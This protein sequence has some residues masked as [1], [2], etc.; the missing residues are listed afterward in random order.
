MKRTTAVFL[1][2]VLLLGA[3][4]ARAG[5]P[6]LPAQI[7]GSVEGDVYRNPYLG[8]GFRAEGWVFLTEEDM[9]ANLAVNSRAMGKDFT[10]EDSALSATVMAASLPGYQD[11]VTVQVIWLGADA[12]LMEDLDEE[13]LMEIW[14]GGLRTSLE[15]DGYT[16]DAFAVE[17]TGINGYDLPCLR[18]EYHSSSVWYMVDVAVACVCFPSEDCLVFVTAAGADPGAA[19]A[20]LRNLFWM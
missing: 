8:F 5:A 3:W 17:E 18:A 2:L 20:A 11:A 4:A 7:R 9:A 6:A 14:S 1:A 16:V 10:P 13:T 12:A 15:D 19:L